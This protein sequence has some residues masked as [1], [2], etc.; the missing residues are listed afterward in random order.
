MTD[1]LPEGIRNYLATV[2]L[3]INS[4]TRNHDPN[5]DYDKA[6]EDLVV[7]LLQL[8][9]RLTAQAL[10]LSSQLPVH[11]VAPRLTT[12]R[13]RSDRPMFLSPS[14]AARPNP[15]PQSLLPASRSFDPFC[16]GSSFIPFS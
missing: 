12:T 10:A 1:Y 2:D 4:I 9:I 3:Q 14:S 15:T 5:D 11:R 7:E 13:L 8:K 6:L 16:A